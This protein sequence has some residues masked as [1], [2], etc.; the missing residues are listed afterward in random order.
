MSDFNKFKKYVFPNILSMLGSSCYVLVDTLFITMIGDNALAALNICLP[1]YSICMGIGSFLSVGASTHYS[2]LKARGKTEEGSKF[3]TFSLTSGLICTSIMAVLILLFKRDVCYMLG[4]NEETID[5]CVQYFNAYVS[6]SPFVVLQYII[7]SF[8]RNDGDP[9]LASIAALSGSLFNLTFDYFFI[10]TLDLGMFGAALATGLSPVVSL[11]VCSSYFFKKKNNFHIVKESIK[12]TIFK[13]IQKL[14][15][16]T[17]I[18][19]FS[20]GIVMLAFNKQLVN[21]GGNKAVTAY[22]IIV[23][24]SVVIEY[25]MNGVSEGSQPLISESYGQK[26]FKQIYS[27]LKMAI[28][29]VIVIFVLGI[30]LDLGF[31][32]YIINFFNSSK[33]IQLLDMTKKGMFIYFFG[34]LGYGLISI[35]M[36]YFTSVEDPKPSN[37]LAILK[38]GVVITP[39]VVILPTYLGLDGVWLSFPISQFIIMFVGIVFVKK[40]KVFINMIK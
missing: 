22:G 8:I 15:M 13:D 5:L 20:S 39:I 6:L 35:F 12:L 17:F 28:M 32:T 11:L 3:F 14:G 4:A 26:K 2:I 27:Y 23:N 37:I 25:L 16:P 24:I 19:S 31:G 36:I 29:M 40:S 9:K 18:N 7:L 33:D 38:A 34:L 10:F 21:I 30:V 1:I